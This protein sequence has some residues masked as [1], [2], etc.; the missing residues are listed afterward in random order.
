M[1]IVFDFDS[2]LIGIESLET[3]ME[4]ALKKYPKDQQAKIIKQIIQITNQGMEGEIT[5]QES[6]EKR[7]QLVNITSEHL[8]KAAH[9]CINHITPG[10]SELIQQLQE[11]HH[12]IYVVSGGPDICVNHVCQKLNI[13]LKNITAIHF[14]FINEIFNSELSTISNKKID[15]V[16]S[17]KLDPQKTVVIGDGATD[18]EIWQKGLAKYFIGFCQFATRQKILS[19]APLIANNT[20]ELKNH[21]NNIYQNSFSTKS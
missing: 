17:F 1:N 3:A 8:E 7:V 18:L 5:L 2:T 20:Q 12:N 21:L 13:P 4:L 14:A 11:N 10:I 6:I 15:A 16:A 9:I 19:D